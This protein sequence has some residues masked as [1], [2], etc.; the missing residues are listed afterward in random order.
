MRRHCVVV[1]LSGC[2]PLLYLHSFPTRRSSDLWIEKNELDN[3]HPLHPYISSFVDREFGSFK[4]PSGDLIDRKSTRLNS[5]HSSISYA[6]SCLKTKKAN[7]SAT[8][9]WRL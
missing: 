2:G 6:V 7:R 3:S 5:S 4:G 1:L 9:S 8:P